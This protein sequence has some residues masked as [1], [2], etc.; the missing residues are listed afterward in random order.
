MWDIILA[1]KTDRVTFEFTLS[2]QG[3]RGNSTSRVVENSTTATDKNLALGREALEGLARKILAKS[4]IL[5]SGTI[6]GDD[7]A[8]VNMAAA[9][10]HSKQPDL[11]GFT[12]VNG[13][14]KD[15]NQNAP[16]A[17]MSSNGLTRRG[18]DE[19]PNGQPRISPPGHEKLTI[20]TSREEWS[21]GERASTRPSYPPNG[22]Y[23]NDTSHKRKRSG[24][25]DQQATTMTYHAHTMPS[26]KATPTTASSEPDS[27]RESAMRPPPPQPDSRDS[28]S[29]Q[30]PYPDSAGG[31]SW[32][33]R[34][35]NPQQ[36]MQMADEQHLGEVIQRET[37]RLDTQNEYGHGTPVDDS[38]PATQYGQHY[39]RDDDSPQSD[40]KKRKRNFS[41]RTK[42]GCMTC[43]RRKKKCDENKPECKSRSQAID[44]N[45][46]F[47]GS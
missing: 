43:R 18:S 32:Y 29:A 16:V 27:A 25:A 6:A 45:R 14:D 34:S 40:M 26:T 23:E 17:S 9:G 39:M 12:A 33:Q 15:Q 24:S 30:T 42:T 20:T 10:E 7:S 8:E 22:P 35:E 21:G 1:K 36:Q 28:Y 4:P 47:V 41:N 5:R 37:Q 3:E 38:R 11:P 31:D 13:K 2:R 19:R 44:F 46:P